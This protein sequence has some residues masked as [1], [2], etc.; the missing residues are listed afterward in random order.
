[1]EGSLPLEE[2]EGGPVAAAAADA[3]AFFAAA[4]RRRNAAPPPAEYDDGSEPLDAALYAHDAAAAAA[5]WDAD[6][7]ASA[8]LIAEDSAEDA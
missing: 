5:E 8:I 7:G 2:D 4:S 6:E 3:A 1:M